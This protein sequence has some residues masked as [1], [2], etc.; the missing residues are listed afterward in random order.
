MVQ[1]I[2]L[3]V[4]LAL[5]TEKKVSQDELSITHSDYNLA[6]TT[7]GATCDASS[8][9]D[10]AHTC[11]NALLGDGSYWQAEGEVTGAWVKVSF[12]TQRIQREIM[13]LR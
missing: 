1:M 10:P 3:N 6:S 5:N 11:L 8:H 13:I 2:F 4:D 12:P 7:E 9:S